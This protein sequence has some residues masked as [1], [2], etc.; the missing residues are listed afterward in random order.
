MIILLNGPLGIGKST[1]A[2]ALTEHIDYC[3]M[4]DGDQLVAANPQPVDELEHLHSTIV[5]LITHHRRFGYR[6]FVVNH[7]WRSSAELADLRERIVAIDANTDIRSF[8]LTLPAD[9]NERRILRR[10][11]ARARDEREFELRTFAEERAVL[12]RHSGLDLGEPFD[13]SAPPSQ[14]VATMLRRLALQEE[15]DEEST[16]SADAD[17][18]DQSVTLHDSDRP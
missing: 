4:L 8:L 6:H 11:G 15:L 18:S 16:T 1:L 13:V 14:L 12:T 3:V 9:E 7:L 2:E 10:Q 17:G 5:L